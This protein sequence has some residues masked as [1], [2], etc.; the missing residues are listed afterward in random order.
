[1]GLPGKR[2]IRGAPAQR[3]RSLFICVRP[4]ASVVRDRLRR[5]RPVAPATGLCFDKQMKIPRFSAQVPFRAR[6]ALAVVFALALS[7]AGCRTASDPGPGKEEVPE[8]TASF[9]EPP[10]PEPQ[11]PDRPA[12]VLPPSAFLLASYSSLEL[13]ITAARDGSIQKVA[14]SKP[15]QARLYDEPTRAWVEKHW[16]M[17]AAR[18]EEPDLRDFIA[19]IVYPK[20]NFKPGGYQPPPPYPHDL[21]VGRVSGFVILEILVATSG[22]VESARA[23]AS[24]GN[25]HLDKYTVDWVL[26]KWSFPAGQKPRWIQWPVSYLIE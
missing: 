25:K 19:P 2:G 26:K 16:K 20:S 7:V 10:P 5:N 17:P 11:D 15:S 18:P 24:S 1:M 3:C 8:S 6:L 9:A 14:I 22:K 4:P 12:P 13:R 23:V 21:L